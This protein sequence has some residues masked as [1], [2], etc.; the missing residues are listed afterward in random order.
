MDILTVLTSEYVDID[1]IAETELTMGSEATLVS[2]PSWWRKAFNVSCSRTA[3]PHNRISAVQQ[4]SSTAVQLNCVIASNR[5]STWRLLSPYT[6][7]MWRQY[8]QA[9][10]RVSLL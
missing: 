4:Y 2:R 6:A 1:T 5:K 8:R 3:R 10:F 9:S 7:N